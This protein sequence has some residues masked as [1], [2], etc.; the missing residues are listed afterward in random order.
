MTDLK[1]L[2]TQALADRAEHTSQ[3]GT[4][5]RDEHYERAVFE[6][7]PALARGYLE[8]EAEVARLHVERDAAQATADS[9]RASALSWQRRETEAIAERDAARAAL[10]DACNLA[11]VAITIAGAPEDGWC[12]GIN[13]ATIAALRTRGGV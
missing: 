11:D 8:L 1:L 13:R 9:W 10:T 3:S 7:E 12:Y 6:R 2:A 5:W 4:V